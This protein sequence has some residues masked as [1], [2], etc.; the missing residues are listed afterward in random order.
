MDD[1]IDTIEEENKLY[2]FPDMN[3]CMISGRLVQ[4]PPL[5]KT[6]KGVPVTNFIIETFPEQPQE[7]G[8]GLEREPCQISVVVWAQQALHCHRNLEKG[9]A[10]LIVGELQSMP[11]ANPGKDFLPVQINAQWIQY[12]EDKL[13]PEPKTET[14]ETTQGDT[15]HPP[16][17]GNDGD[18]NKVEYDHEEVAESGEKAEQ[19]QVADDGENLNTDRSAPSGERDNFSK[20]DPSDNENTK[21]DNAENDGD[22][23]DQD[24]QNGF[25]HNK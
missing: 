23:R 13:G 18:Q 16:T 6:K 14:S 25:E 12:L 10:I 3:K 19:I 22:F 15:A 4:N 9:D 1:K 21:Q 17:S 5:R 7:S 8:E 20:D 11:N 2:A 24:F